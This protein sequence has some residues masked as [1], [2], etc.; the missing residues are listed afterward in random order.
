MRV[1]RLFAAAVVA[2][3][4][5]SPADASPEDIYGWGPR[6]TAMGGTGAASSAGADAAYTNPAL[7]S[8]VHANE[9]TLGFAG[10][11]F[12]LNATGAQLPGRVSEQPAKGYI[13]GVAVPIPFGGVL[14]D[15]I[16]AGLAGYTPT[17]VLSRVNIL[18]PETPEYALLA[19]RSQ[20]L[21]VRSGAGA[22]LG[23][24]LRFGAGLG[25]LAELIGE[26]DVATT[27]GTVGAHVDTQLLAT[28]APTFGLAWDVPIDR[29]PDGKPRWRVG[30]TWRGSLAAPFTVTVDASK[31]SALNLPL[32]N[33]AGIAQYDPE[34]A[35][36][37]VAREAD[38][39]TV[40]AGITWK[41]WSQYPGVFE[42]TIVCPAGQTCTLLSPP[43]IN[44][45]DTIVPRVG[46]EKKFPLPRRAAVRVRG[47]FLLEPTPLPSSLPPSLAYDVK[48]GLDSPV[49]ARFFDTTRYV[50]SLGW[51]ADFGERLPFTVDFYAQVHLLANSTVATPPA[52]QASLSGSVLAYGVFLGVRF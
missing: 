16:A 30:A 19:D 22:D 52:S 46:V 10:A 18:Y 7:L 14:K 51:G 28:Y 4:W 23:W 31:L 6:S 32:F 41:R 37:E 35:V 11:T 33:I 12:D 13:V 49:P 43:Q 9:L 47:G 26:I 8:R 15:R 29:G 17:D 44:F 38:D 25:M 24:G 48:T 2:L 50:F 1:P 21:A 27:A 3:A 36:F 42:P 20:V 40:A 45:S 5:P 39:W 34:E